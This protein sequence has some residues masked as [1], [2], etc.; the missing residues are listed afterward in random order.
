MPKN[1]YYMR[2]KSKMQ[3]TLPHAFVTKSTIFAYTFL[4]RVRSMQDSIFNLLMIILMMENGGGT[5]NINQLILM[6]LL[7]NSQNSSSAAE[8]REQLSRRFCNCGREDGFT[9]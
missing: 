8:A 9:F 6:F 7:M 4:S 2:N 3:N 1:Y 5:E